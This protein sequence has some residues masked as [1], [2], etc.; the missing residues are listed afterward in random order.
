MNKQTLGLLFIAII[1]LYF[2]YNNIES[3]ESFGILE[4]FSEKER[5]EHERKEHE[6]KTHERRRHEAAKKHETTPESHPESHPESMTETPSHT[7]TESPVE[8]LSILVSEVNGVEVAEVDG[9]HFS[10]G[11]QVMK[12]DPGALVEKSYNPAGTDRYGVGQYPGGQARVYTSSAFLPARLHLSYATGPSTFEDVVT[13]ARDG[14]KV[15]TGKVNAQIDTR[16]LNQSPE[17]YLNRGVGKHTEL[18][19]CSV[20]GLPTAPSTLAPRSGTF[21]TVETTISWVDFSGGLIKQ[22]AYAD[23]GMF[24]RVGGEG[25]GWGQW[26]RMSPPT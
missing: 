2:V 21:A 23:S 18:K 13:I 4:G 10:S 14:M 15:N 17:D 20:V 24:Y 9:M 26:V 6:R 5:R 25:K 7:A 19:L 3:F 1:V 8:P 16:N 22:M 12:T 11:I